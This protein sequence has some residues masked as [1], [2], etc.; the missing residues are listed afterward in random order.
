VAATH[1]NG[2]IDTTVLVSSFRRFR[3][4]N[5]GA[6]SLWVT[7]HPYTIH[8]AQLPSYLT[9]KWNEYLSPSS[10]T[11][12][13]L[14]PTSLHVLISWSCFY[15]IITKILLSLDLQQPQF[16]HDKRSRSRPN[17]TCSR[18]RCIVWTMNEAAGMRV[19]TLLSGSCK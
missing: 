3:R 4:F 19:T 16:L 7:V 2:I 11:C 1:H 6:F 10:H 13:L 14:V 15:T 18:T 9:W 8:T 5:R 12:P 17:R